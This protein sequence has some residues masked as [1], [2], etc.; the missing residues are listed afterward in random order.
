MN[1]LLLIRSYA[2]DDRLDALALAWHEEPS[3]FAPTYVTWVAGYGRKV[4]K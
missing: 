4:A 3:H 1:L 2:F